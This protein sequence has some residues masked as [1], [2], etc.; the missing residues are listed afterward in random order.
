[1]AIEWPLVLFTAL[2]GCG[3]WL[4]V[5]VAIDLF[6]RKAQKADAVATVVAVILL[7]VG[8]CASVLHLQHPDRILG[9]LSHPTSGIFIEAVLVG[10][11]ALALAVLFVMMKRGT[12]DGAC[13]AVA[14]IAAAL[15]VALS[16]MAG[17]SYMMASIPAWNTLLLPLGYMLTAAPSG[18]AVYGLIAAL[19]GN[20]EVPPL[21]GK[22]LAACGIAA[23]LG[24]AAYAAAS[25]A[26]SSALCLLAASVLSGGLAPTICGLLSVRSS[27]AAKAVLSIAAVCAIAG[28]IAFRCAMWLSGE[29]SSNFFANM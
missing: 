5:C 28:A 19:K 9:A 14:V 7:A 17:H 27:K 1:M 15:G 16:F 3:G 18:V 24:A 2:T 10:L 23:A 6:A 12:A 22:V 26:A 13:R 8:G 25:H 29:A 11:C 21:Y 20:G 4:A